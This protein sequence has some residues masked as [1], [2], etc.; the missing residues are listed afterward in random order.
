MDGILLGSGLRMANATVHHAGCPSRGSSLG[1]NLSDFNVA[2]FPAP[3]LLWE[4]SAEASR[5]SQLARG[6]LVSLLNASE[7]HFMLAAAESELVA[8]LAQHITSRV[9]RADLPTTRAARDHNR[10]A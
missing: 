7:P 9:R 10:A 5:A 6:F 3:T 4:A 8:G 2:L 1:K